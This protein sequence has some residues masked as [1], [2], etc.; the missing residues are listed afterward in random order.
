[1]SA[2]SLQDRYTAGLLQGDR[3]ACRTLFKQAIDSAAGTGDLYESLLWP[4]MEHIETL[5]RTHRINSAT[6]HMATRINRV[7]A[8]QLQ[9]HLPVQPAIG[10]RIL[11]GCADHEP[12]ELGA[13]MIA[14]RF[15]AVGWTVHFTGG[16]VPNDEIL[17]LVGSLRPDVLLIFGT[18]PR[19]V[20]QVRALVDLIRE[21]DSNPTMNILISGGVFNRAE[22]LW[23]EINA[24]L[25]APTASEALEI[26]SEAP[27]R[28][29]QPRPLNAPKKRRRRRRQPVVA[30]ATAEN[31]DT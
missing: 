19:G 22:G 4:A 14:D 21:I 27:P 7:I 6:E 30:E 24:D 17:G 31:K 9:S 8:D 2:T 1:M 10:K 11:I 18:R 20:P 13:Q 16:G 12:E 26:A 23:L 5:Y 3:V 29:P 28:I 15:E 25:F